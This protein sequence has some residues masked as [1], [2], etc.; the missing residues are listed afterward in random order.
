MTVEQSILFAFLITGCFLL[1]LGIEDRKNLW[2]SK[3][4]FYLFI[5]FQAGIFILAPF[6]LKVIGLLVIGAM[7]LL[8]YNLPMNQADKI[9]LTLTLLTTS[10]ISIP[11]L[12]LTMTK[13]KE[14]APFI[15]IYF[16]AY[17]TSASIILLINSQLH[18]F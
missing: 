1:V 15:W 8:I 13:Y 12:M 7:S 6:E 16:L 2:I 17:L 18:F 3:N 4:I 11:A 9:I 14:N 5:I 10:I